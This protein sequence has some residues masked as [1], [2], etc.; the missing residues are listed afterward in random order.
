MT[1]VDLLAFLRALKERYL[2]QFPDGRER[3]RW[4]GLVY[5][6]TRP[7]WLRYSDFAEDPPRIVELTAEQLESLA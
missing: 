3:Q 5:V 4:P 7:T 2:R 1:R 6:R